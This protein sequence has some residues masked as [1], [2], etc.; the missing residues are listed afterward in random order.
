MLVKPRLGSRRCRGICPPSNPILDE[1]P[2]RDFCPFSPRPAVL[3]SPEPGPRPTRFFLCV[4]P[5]DGCRLLRLS[6]IIRSRIRPQFLSFND[7]QQMRQFGY[8]TA[9]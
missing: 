5:F 1:Y 7:P 4:E 6:A 2:E 9:H 3:P 8:D